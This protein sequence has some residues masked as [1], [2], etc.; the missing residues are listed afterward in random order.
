[1]DLRNRYTV[2]TGASSGLGLE[3]AR[4][5]AK[6]HGGHLV[7]VARRR[8]RL[9]AL[10]E[11][12]SSVDVV[13]IVADLSR[14]E[15]VE[16]TFAEA[17]N[18]RSVYGAILNAGVTFYGRALEQPQQA[19]DSMLATNVTSLVHLANR[20]VEHIAAQPARGG[21]MLVSSLAGFSPTP[22]QAAY[23]ATKAFVTS[24][25]QSLG[26]EV[27]GT[28]VSVTVF[29]PGGI[30]TEM[31][32]L[33]GLSRKFKHDD[34]GVMTAEETARLAVRAF[35]RRQRLYVPGFVNQLG[36]TAIKLMP[37]SLVIGRIAAL[38]REDS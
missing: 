37:R 14:P 28:G 35:V 13:P 16:R 26:Y 7:V 1:M 15:D 38:F 32:E 8:E 27:Q 11:E 23:G 21:L 22:Y 5:I 4:H 30:A 25:G 29:A 34:F 24:Y 36:A 31:Q 6:D 9:E 20:F 3:I 12:L 19:F 33:S 18:G 10:R 2:V 17:T